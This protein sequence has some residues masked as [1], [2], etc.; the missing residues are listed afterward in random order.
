[1]FQIRHVLAYYIH[2]TGPTAS[3]VDL[4]NSQLIVYV[5]RARCCRGMETQQAV[6]IRRSSRLCAGPTAADRTQDWRSEG[7]WLRP[8]VQ[9]DQAAQL[10]P[11]AAGLHALRAGPPQLRR[12]EPRHDGAAAGP[13]DAAAALPVA[14]PTPSQSL[15]CGWSSRCCCSV[16]QPPPPPYPN[17]IFDQAHKCSIPWWTAFAASPPPPP[18]VIVE[19]MLTALS[20]DIL[21]LFTRLVKF[22]FLTWRNA[23]HECL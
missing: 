22:C 18:H 10:T 5:R 19:S 8:S 15:A 9:A 3:E 21:A 11:L 16:A 6:R 4:E 1:V 17:T 13:R 20:I 14:H 23:Y 12:P 7:Q 2:L